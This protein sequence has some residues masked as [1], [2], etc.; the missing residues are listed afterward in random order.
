M[1]ATIIIQSEEQVHYAPMAAREVA[2]AATTAAVAGDSSTFS[3]TVSVSSAFGVELLS[4]DFDGAA[5]GAVASGESDF[6][7]FFFFLSRPTR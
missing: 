3:T 4:E 7:F 6:A 2:A 5:T 1:L